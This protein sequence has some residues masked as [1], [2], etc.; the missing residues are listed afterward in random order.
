MRRT[1][2][3][4]TTLAALSV[5]AAACGSNSTGPSNQTPVLSQLQCAQANGT[6]VNCDL[7]LTQAGGFEVKL[8]SHTC[9]AVGDTIRLTKPV[10]A[11]LTSDGCYAAVDTT[12]TYAGP[13]PSGTPVA[14]VFATGTLGGVNVG[15]SHTGLHVTGSYPQWELDYEDGGAPWDYQDIVLSV[16][17]F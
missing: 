7:T 12:W 13:Y 6:W 17:A 3:H 15:N 5:S 10:A 4:V 16:R 2:L 14:L 1:S 8:L 9:G 11:V